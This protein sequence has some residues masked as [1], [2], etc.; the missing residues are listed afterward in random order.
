MQDK[1]KIIELEK[2]N[3]QIE[4]EKI[5]LSSKIKE[6]ED[7]LSSL[8][9][10]NEKVSKELTK[11]TLEVEYGKREVE[12]DKFIHEGRVTPSQKDRALKLS[13][14]GYEGFKVSIPE[15]PVVNMSP[16]GSGGT[17][18]EPKG[19][20]DREIKLDRRAWELIEDGKAMDYKQALNM[21]VEE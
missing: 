17:P 1:E 15:K 18:T 14:E 3:N 10:E 13:K 5:K 19:D 20:L 21:A 4:S 2:K 6:L 7:G 9:L 8:K 12:L 11:K 16:K